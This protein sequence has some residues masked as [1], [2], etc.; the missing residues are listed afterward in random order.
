[1]TETAK[2]GRPRKVGAKVAVTLR[3]DPDVAAAYQ[4][5]GDDWRLAMAAAVVNAA[6]MAFGAGLKAAKPTTLKD[7]VA[8]LPSAPRKANTEAWPDA[9]RA[10]KA[11]AEPAPKPKVSVSV[12]LK[13]NERRPYGSLQKR[14]KK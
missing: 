13:T 14:G 6:P 11:M 8:A 3:L 10:L 7:V 1:M 12:P 9:G 4:A 2:R 5:K